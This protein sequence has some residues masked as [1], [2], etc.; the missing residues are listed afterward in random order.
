MKPAWAGAPQLPRCACGAPGVRRCCF[1][2]ADARRGQPDEFIARVL[3]KVCGKPL[4]DTCAVPVGPGR[5]Q[6]KEHAG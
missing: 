4:C 5:E 1:D 6:C 2:P 3:M